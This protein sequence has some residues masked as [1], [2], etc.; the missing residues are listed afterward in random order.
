MENSLKVFIII[1]I[2]SIIIIIFIK[3]SLYQFNKEFQKTLNENEKNINELY[4]FSYD[5]YFHNQPNEIIVSNP[6]NCTPTD[7]RLCDVNNPFSCEGCKSLIS[8]CTHISKE[9]KYYDFDGNEFLITP[10]ENENEGYCLAQTNPNQVCNPY[11]GDL[12]FIQTEPDSYENMLF[13]QCKNPGFIGKSQ[14]DGA[15]DEVFICNGKIDNINQP[16]EEIK[17]Q[18]ENGTIF[19]LINNIPSCITPSVNDYTNFDDTFYYEGVDVV[20]TDRF[21]GDISNIGKFPGNKIKNPCKYCLVTGKYIDNGDMIK[22]EDDGW[23]CILKSAK[24]GGLPIRRNNNYRILKGNAGPDAII[25]LNIFELYVHGYL[26]ET[27]FEQMTA[28]FITDENKQVLQYFGIDTTK[29]YT[30]LNLQSHQLVFPQSFG[31]MNFVNFPGVICDGPEIPLY[32]WDD[33]VYSC[34]FSNEIDWDRNPK[35]HF[36]YKTFYTSNIQFSTAP[37]CPAK[38]HSL[39]SSSA[40]KKWDEYEGYNSAHSPQ[41]VNNLAKY[42]LSQDYKNSETIKYLFSKYNFITFESRHY[43]T[44]NIDVYRKWFAITIPK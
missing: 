39:V 21:I 15:C 31:S 22:T 18:C 3:L 38:H 43:G 2:F 34:D 4:A 14:I 25:N 40:F 7:L 42:E 1:A 41:V 44:K 16:L 5:I 23:Q 8:T 37:K 13:C 30:F 10:N 26:N 20:D 6:Y 36:S 11:H 27:I 24:G 33:L 35:D 28:V 29:T 17:C 9:T 12:V 32:M 19:E